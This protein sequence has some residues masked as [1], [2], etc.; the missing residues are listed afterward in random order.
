MQSKRLYILL[1]GVMLLW[2]FVACTSLDTTA[3]H[4]TAPTVTTS[5][6]TT[7]AVTTE[8]PD[9]LQAIA[10]RVMTSE[11][12]QDEALIGQ[13]VRFSV[14]RSLDAVYR[15]FDGV[16]SDYTNTALLCGYDTRY[17]E[18]NTVILLSLR[19]AYSDE[20]FFVESVDA[21]QDQVKI[22]VGSHKTKKA[23]NESVYAL[24][25]VILSD[26]SYKYETK[27]VTVIRRESETL[28]EDAYIGQYPSEQAL[29]YTATVLRSH[30][31]T[32]FD[33]RGFVQKITSRE[34]LDALIETRYS[35]SEEDRAILDGYTD[36]YFS[37]NTLVLA[38]VLASSGS[39]RFFVDRVVSDGK[40]LSVIIGGNTKQGSGETDDM[41]YWT[42]WITLS[43]SAE[44]WQETALSVKTLPIEPI[45][46]EEFD[47]KYSAS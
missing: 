20:R 12:V 16:T 47:A 23:T 2:L 4:T 9:S 32:D 40:T 19:G 13:D 24:L 26:V 1:F 28:S 27:D 30:P 45:S 15:F 10:Y 33:Y 21:T 44:K 22:T 5:P 7:V 42:A 17:Y 34:A 29:M 36:A 25:W 18:D 35:L 41:A 8:S 11:I 6:E 3:V 37:E 38:D 31:S 14:V 46:P 43:G 39:H